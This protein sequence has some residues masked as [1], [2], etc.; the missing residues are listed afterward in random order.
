MA[1]VVVAAVAVVVAAVVVAVAVVVAAAV[2][3]V[4]AVAVPSMSKNLD[5]GRN[6][7]KVIDFHVNVVA[8]NNDSSITNASHNCNTTTRKAAGA[9]TPITFSLRLSLFLLQHKS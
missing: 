5:A 3:V 7:H 4:V 2:V 1:V 8:N 9:T 6:A